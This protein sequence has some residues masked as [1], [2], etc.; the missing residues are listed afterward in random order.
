MLGAAGKMRT[1][2]PGHENRGE[3][4]AMNNRKSLENHCT[5]SEW[6]EQPVV[7]KPLRQV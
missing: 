4:E 7:Y 1:L 5:N 3:C 2:T 6:K